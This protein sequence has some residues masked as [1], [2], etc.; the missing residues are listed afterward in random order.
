MSAMT[1]A[2]LRPSGVLLGCLPAD[3]RLGAGLEGGVGADDVF[4]GAEDAQVGHAVGG[5][6]GGDSAGAGGCFHAAHDGG[7][8][9]FG[10]DPGCCPGHCLHAQAAEHRGQAG[11]DLGTV[12]GG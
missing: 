10:G 8:V 12:S 4:E 11:V 3:H 6:A 9:E 1:A 2:T 7:G 5:G